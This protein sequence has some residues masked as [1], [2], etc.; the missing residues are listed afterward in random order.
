MNRF[1]LLDP[2][3]W[4]ECTPVLTELERLREKIAKL[5]AE[6]ERLQAIIHKQI[7]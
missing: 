6:I 7:Y 5:E 2:D 1:D 4:A 3:T